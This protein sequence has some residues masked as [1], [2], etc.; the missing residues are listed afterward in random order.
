[1]R[2]GRCSRTSSGRDTLTGRAQLQ[3][4]QGYQQIVVLSLQPQPHL[5]VPATM[6]GQ[7]PETRVQFPLAPPGFVK[8]TRQLLSS[9]LPGMKL[10]TNPLAGPWP[11]GRAPVL[12]RTP[13]AR[14][15]DTAAPCVLL[16]KQDGGSTPPPL[17]GWRN[18]QT[19]VRKQ[20]PLAQGRAGG[21]A[22]SVSWYQDAVW[23]GLPGRAWYGLAGA[24]ILS[25]VQV[26][27]CRCTRSCTAGLLP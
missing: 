8:A 2:P 4:Q 22:V 27:E 3:S 19:H 10:V 21:P 12:S 6:T 9:D 25:A 26:P 17:S 7:V 15:D 16:V 18:R 24:V 14:R 5:P 1:M 23:Y 11:S 13:A 20:G